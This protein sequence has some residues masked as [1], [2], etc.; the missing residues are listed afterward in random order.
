M[1][2]PVFIDGTLDRKRKKNERGAKQ[3]GRNDPNIGPVHELQHILF[4]LR[5]AG[6]GMVRREATEMKGGESAEGPNRMGETW[7]YR[8]L[9]GLDQ[10]YMT[11][12]A[13]L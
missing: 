6:L 12:T 9:E 10:V 1:E 3:P 2:R 13:R 4:S 8:N 11:A 5:N 7:L